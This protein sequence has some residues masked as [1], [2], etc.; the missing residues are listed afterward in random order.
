MGLSTGSSVEERRVSSDLPPDIA[1]KKMTAGLLA[2][3]IGTFGIHK[4]VLGYQTA[5]LIMLLVTVLTCFAASPIM[6]V[7]GVVEGILYLTKSDEEFYRTYILGKK[8][9]F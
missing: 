6:T 5:G 1:S 2:I 3:L 8:E 7:I 4:F 9:W